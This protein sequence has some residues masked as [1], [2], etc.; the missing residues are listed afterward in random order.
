MLNSSHM[1]AQLIKI[2]PTHSKKRKP[3]ELIGRYLK[4]WWLYIVV[5]SGKLT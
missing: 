3:G 4:K 1:D 2:D 5:P